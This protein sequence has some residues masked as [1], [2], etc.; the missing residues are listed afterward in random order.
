MARRLGEDETLLKF[1]QSMSSFGLVGLKRLSLF[2][3]TPVCSRQTPILQP[4]AIGDVGST[5]RANRICKR[6]SVQIVKI[7]IYGSRACHC[8]L[9]HSV[10]SVISPCEAYHTG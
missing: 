3:G 4:T 5:V 7:K 10:G 1:F 9:Q 8:G 6:S 2:R